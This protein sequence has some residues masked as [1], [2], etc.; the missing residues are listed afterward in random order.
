MGCCLSKIRRNVS[1]IEILDYTSSGSE[2][3]YLRLEEK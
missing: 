1:N 2:Y 3:D